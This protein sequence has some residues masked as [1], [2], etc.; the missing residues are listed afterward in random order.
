MQFLILFKSTN[1]FHWI[2]CMQHVG[3]STLICNLVATTNTK[4]S[5]ALRRGLVN[6]WSWT[7]WCCIRVSHHC[8]VMKSLLWLHLQRTA[9]KP[10]SWSGAFG[11]PVSMVTVFHPDPRTGTSL[12]C[13]SRQQMLV[14]W[15]EFLRYVSLGEFLRDKQW[16]WAE[17][18]SLHQT[19]WLDGVFS[20]TP[21]IIIH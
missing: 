15:G 6:S 1:G 20:E 3:C 4:M 13:H 21:S 14:A 9:L 12:H 16:F 5:I 18:D 11:G 2:C 17:P 19:V 8:Y 7:V 10:C